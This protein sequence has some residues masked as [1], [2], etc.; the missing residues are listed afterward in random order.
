MTIPSKPARAFNISNQYDDN[1]LQPVDR[2]TTI[3]WNKALD[4]LTEGGTFWLTTTVDGVRPHT[5]PV[6][7]VVAN[8]ALCTATSAAAIKMTG[9]RRGAPVSLATSCDGLDFVWA[10][11]PSQVTDIDALCEVV[12]AYRRTYGWEVEI[13]GEGLL[14]PYGAPTAGPPPY[15]VFRIEPVTVHAVGTDPTFAGCSTRWEFSRPTSD[16]LP[17]PIIVAGHLTVDSIAR[18]DYLRSCEAVVRAA[19]A[20]DGCLD[21]AISADLAEPTRINIH[22]HWRDPSTLAAFRDH[23]PGDEQMAMLIDINVDEYQIHQ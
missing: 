6:F 7:A 11:T 20:A 10:G 16:A 5:R 17:G 23:G 1:E 19:R 8:G 14:A 12:I 3:G 18:D 2:T 21:F 9:L 22:E 13:D 4:R 15:L